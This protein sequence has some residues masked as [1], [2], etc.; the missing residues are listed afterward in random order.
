MSYFNTDEEDNSIMDHYADMADNATPAE[1]ESEPETET[2]S[3][4]PAEPAAETAAPVDPLDDPGWSLD[5]LDKPNLVDGVDSPAT[6]LPDA[7]SAAS[8]D[9]LAPL[10]QFGGIEGAVG[11]LQIVDQLISATPD[12]VTSFLQTMYDSAQPAYAQLVEQVVA[13]NPEFAIQQLQASGHLP[14]TFDSMMAPP[15]EISSIEPEVLESIPEHLREIAMKLPAEMQEDL[16]LMTDAVRN[17][18]LSD[19]KELADMR[20]YQ[21]QQTQAAEQAR[22]E[23]AVQAGF[24]QREAL[25]SQLEAGHMKVLEKWQPWGPEAKDDNQMLYES[26]MEGAMSTVLKD[27]KFAQMYR[28]FNTLITEAPMKALTG[29]KLAAEAATRQA[30][31]LAAQFNTQYSRVLQ[32]R[33]AKFDQVFRSSRGTQNNQ[34]STPERKEVRGST[35]SDGRKVSAIGPDGQATDEFLSSLAA[36]IK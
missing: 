36:L 3:A 5:S 34:A 16:N 11:T 20:A 13:Y 22:H 28:D 14:A 35:I 21:Q 19:K 32:S 10:E 18:T 9:I 31:G 33:V 4:S 17:Q 6:D 2:A 23:Q 8:N 7:A 27:P 24:E 12:G 26:L 25:L 1:P 29:N 30:R 15:P